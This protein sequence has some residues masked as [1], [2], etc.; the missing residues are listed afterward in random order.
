MIYDIRVFN[1]KGE[2]TNIIN[3]KKLYDIKYEEIAKSIAKTAWGKHTK[4]YKTKPVTCPICKVTVEG[5]AN[6]ITCGSAKCIREREQIKKYPKSLRK[7]KCPEC[8]VKIE[9]RHHNK[10]T[11]GLQECFV[12][13]RIKGEKLR[14]KK[15]KEKKDGFQKNSK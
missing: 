13:N 14:I 2:L 1:P 15:L 9:T 11:C 7:F 5:R 10:K 8:G 6:Q 12:K 4:I 3:G